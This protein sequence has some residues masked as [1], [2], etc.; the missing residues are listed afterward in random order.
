[1]KKDNNQALAYF[2]AILGI[3]ICFTI[4]GIIATQ[5]IAK[6][7]NYSPSLGETFIYGFYNPLNFIFWSK[8]YYSYYPEFFNQFFIFL[9][10]GVAFC[11]IMFIII[12][13]IFIRK[14]KAIKDLHGSARWANIKDIEE[15]GILN[16][17]DGVYIGGFQ[18][19]K[20]TYY[21]RH[22]GPEHVIAFAPTRS[23]KGVGLVLPTLLS[24]I[25]SALII[26]IKGELWA[27]TAGWRKKYAK[28]KVLKF[29]PTCT[30][31]SGA[32][33]NILEEI[34]INTIHEIKDTQ[35]IAI[36]LIYKGETPPNNNHTNT[37]YFKNEAVSFL[38]AVI[39]YM[40]NYSR[41]LGK[42]TPS[43]TKL[44]KF[45]NNPEMSIEELLAEMIDCDLNIQNDTKEI[46]QSVARSISNKATQELSGV[47][48]SAVES[49]NLYVDP[50]ITKNISKS[51]FKIKD[52]M[53]NENPVS[54]YITIPPSDKDR[55]KPL[56]NLIINQIL[57]A[58]T[59]ESLNFK[60]GK[61]INN[62]KHKLLFMGDEIASL[63]KLG[64]LE[65]N[66]AY[67][68][69]Y[70]IK[71][72]LIIQDITQLHSLYGKEESIIS[73][74]HVRIAYAPNKLET[75]KILS[76][77]SGITTIIKKA[78]T[79]SGGR[80]SVMLNNVS[81]TIQEIQRPLIT[82]DECMRIK[83]ARKNKKT[84]DIIEAGDML[85]FLAGSLPVYG[86]QI[87]YF[88]DET[89]LERSKVSLSS[90]ISDI[91]IQEKK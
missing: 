32:K 38:T 64:V 5:Y 10:L 62:Y 51:E 54:L 66:I 82:D 71:Y 68:A 3:F 19:G 28:N 69:G 90:K 18:Q 39:L 14:S 33:F 56:N 37:S 11:F 15:M 80:M 27:L 44:F 17:N 67:A 23:G 63:G 78:I 6:S 31:N 2:F 35:N 12:R 86:K 89:F 46:I 61:N 7:F 47:I 74:C 8:Q 25:H 55:L 30:D 60:D 26:D 24:W 43:L 65:E 45:I 13:L 85:I 57:R 91:I 52:L 29:D 75:A 76:G 48:G 58:L 41:E 49:L 59:D 50:I 87:L 40:L 34:R 16:N 9:G 22:N 84:G 70:G 73:N 4:L 83:T 1:M 88:Q 81:E 21:L 79:S 36:N 72:Y 42:T 53:N 77:M 20:N